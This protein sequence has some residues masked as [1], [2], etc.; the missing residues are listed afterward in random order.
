MSERK[1]TD[2]KSPSYTPEYNAGA[3]RL[4]VE[5]VRAVSQVAKE[6]GVS[7]TALR[8]WR[9]ASKAVPGREP[10]TGALTASERPEPAQLRR[11]NRKLTEEREIIK[12]AAAFFARESR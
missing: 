10:K 2:Y 8:E 6:L 5:E 9:I 1:K 3:L 7:Q 4:I 12:K 11:E